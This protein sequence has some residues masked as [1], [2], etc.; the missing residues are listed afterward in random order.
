MAVSTKPFDF[1]RKTLQ[2]LCTDWG[3]CYG[4]VYQILYK[5]SNA[6]LTD[7][8]QLLLYSYFLKQSV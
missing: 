8:T 3:Q 2:P 7:V 4:F 1:T 6:H 5:F